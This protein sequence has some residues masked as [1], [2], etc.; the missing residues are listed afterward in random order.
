[1]AVSL[2]YTFF[3]PSTEG[4]MRPDLSRFSSRPQ[5]RGG[6]RLFPVLLAERFSRPAKSVR[7]RGMAVDRAPYGSLCPCWFASQLSN[8]SQTLPDGK[9]QPH[10]H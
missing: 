9:T 3:R 10:H 8:F 4:A 2:P 1:M 7:V 5:R 6:D